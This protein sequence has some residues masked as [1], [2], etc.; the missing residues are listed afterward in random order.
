[1]IHYHGLPINPDTAAVE[2]IGGGHAFISYVR[3]HQISLAQSVCQSFAVDNGA[4]SYWKQGEAAPDW[5]GYYEWLKPILNHPG[6][7][8]AVIPDV[9]DGTEVQNNRLIQE[10]PFERWQGAPVWHLHESL[11]RLAILAQN[12]PRVCLGSSGE[13]S[14]VGTEA[15]WERMSDAMNVVCDSDGRPACKLHGL[16]MLNPRV[17]TK[18]PLS[19]ADSTTIARSIGMDKRWARGAHLPPNKQARARVMRSRIEVYNSAERWVGPTHLNYETLVD[20]DE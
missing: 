7:D 10:W 12:F 3:P 13:F 4:Y 2:T 11:E 16:R 1:M 8:F 6:F 9:V 18:L 14:A 19:S 17:F 5:K 15:W 20:L